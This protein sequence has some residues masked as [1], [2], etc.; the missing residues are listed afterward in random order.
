MKNIIMG[1]VAYI[2]A[3]KISGEIYLKNE[4]L[5]M[6][7]NPDS[8]NA[9]SIKEF[10]DN[11]YERASFY[12]RKNN[13]KSIQFLENLETDA[14]G[15]SMIC[16]GNYEGE[17]SKLKDGIERGFPD[18]WLDILAKHDKRFSMDNIQETQSKYKNSEALRRND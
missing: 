12:K 10:V 17:Y 7:V 13:S 3:P 6:R 5:K 15:I 4:L 18:P 14:I 9:E 11:S 8:I 16:F 1:F 2:F